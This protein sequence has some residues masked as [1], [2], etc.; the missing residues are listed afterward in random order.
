MLCQNCERPIEPTDEQCPHCGAKPLH[1]RV[2]LGSRREEFALTAEEEPYEIGE[3]P[4]AR[5]WPIASEAS[6]TRDP[7]IEEK[8][9]ARDHE[10]R[11]GG[12]IRRACAMVIDLIVVSALV[13]VL[14]FLIY[15]GHR[16]EIRRSRAN[17]KS[18]P[19]LRHDFLCHRGGNGSNDEKLCPL[20]LQ[21]ACQ[22]CR[23]QILK[24]GEQKE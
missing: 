14:G 11:W 21:P 4:E 6:A 19:R 2:Y 23:F 7:Q 10:V 8:S 22:I 15:I 17:R 20:H 16:V 5:D 18:K 24:M 9:H 13:L 1:R 12:F 3:N